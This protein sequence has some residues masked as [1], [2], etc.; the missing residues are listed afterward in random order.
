MSAEQLSEP[1]YEPMCWTELPHPGDARGPKPARLQA[2]MMQ[3]KRDPALES[4][5]RRGCF[6]GHNTQ[7]GIDN[8]Y[9]SIEAHALEC[10]M[11][12]EQRANEE[13]KEEHTKRPIWRRAA[14]KLVKGARKL[15]FSCVA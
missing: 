9:R 2:S 3:R 15:V 7:D 4:F 12:K 6:D 13:P 1:L 14:H 10:E 11:A 5:A 8:W